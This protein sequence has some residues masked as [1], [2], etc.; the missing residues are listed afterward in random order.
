MSSAPVTGGCSSTTRS[1]LTKITGKPGNNMK[2]ATLLKLHEAAC[3]KA[4]K[5]MEVKNNDY[6]GGENAEDALANFKAAT[7]LGLHPITGLLLRMQDKLQ[8]LRS[9]AA[10]G[11]LE[12]PNESA[13]DACIDLLNY[14]IL[15]KALIEE[16][17][18]DAATA[19]TER[20]KMDWVADLN[21]DME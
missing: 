5:I 19:L 2:R 7:S 20:R 12:V 15:A 9:F 4:L 3:K 1:T 6:S 18:L 11:K 8:R 14:A 21:D 16:S 10:D 13:E 17:A